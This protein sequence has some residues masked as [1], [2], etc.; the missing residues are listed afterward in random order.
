MGNFQCAE[1]LADALYL[2]ARKNWE[3]HCA[4]KRSADYD[5]AR[6]CLKH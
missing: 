5:G 3:S 1:R 4:P 6:T 2:Q